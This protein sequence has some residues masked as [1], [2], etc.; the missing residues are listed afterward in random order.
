MSQVLGQVNLSG[1]MAQVP[2]FW[3]EC[4]LHRRHEE[5]F[6]F[7][8]AF[9]SITNGYYVEQVIADS[10]VWKHNQKLL[11][12]GIAEIAVQE[13]RMLDEV[14][15]V[16]GFQKPHAIQRQLRRTCDICMRLFR[17]FRQRHFDKSVPTK[18]P[19]QTAQISAPKQVSYSLLAN[20]VVAPLSQPQ[21]IQT[22]AG[23]AAPPAQALPAAPA[24]LAPP[25]QALPAAPKHPNM[26]RVKED[27]DAGCELEGGYLSL[28]VGQLIKEWPH[29]RVS[30]HWGF[31]V[32]FPTRHNEYMYGT[33][34]HING[35]HIAS[36]WLPVV[37]L[38]SAWSD[39]QPDISRRWQ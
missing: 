39:L 3:W 14:V 18:P 20:P 4:N 23:S 29:S 22:P 16:N 38:E 25:A 6:G 15:E 12:L 11:S 13:V 17:P 32:A 30:E 24:E 26:H 34:V 8:I 9:S 37:C 19:S 2:G 27:Y 1:A 36:G 7:V 31:G 5:K 35:E 10:V 33:L 21:A 28:R